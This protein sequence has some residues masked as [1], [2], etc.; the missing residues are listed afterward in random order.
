M[1]TALRELE[2]LPV[3]E[4][5]LLVE[6]LWDSIARSAA[7]PTVSQWQKDELDRR[8]AEFAREPEAAVPWE[9]AKRSIL[10]GR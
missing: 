8:R 1:T 7:A 4:R 6:D 5:L 9:E 3:A 2:Q 10:A